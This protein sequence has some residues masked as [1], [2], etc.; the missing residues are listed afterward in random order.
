MYTAVQFNDKQVF[1]TVKINDKFIAK[2]VLPSK[3]LTRQLSITQG[4]PK[5]FFRFSLTLA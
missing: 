4:R 5:H 3:L 1:M 2:A